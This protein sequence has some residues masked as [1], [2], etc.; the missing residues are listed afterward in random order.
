VP[1][2]ECAKVRNFGQKYGVF[3]TLYIMK[4]ASYDLFDTFPAKVKDKTFI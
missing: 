3:K 4:E 1:R 2:K